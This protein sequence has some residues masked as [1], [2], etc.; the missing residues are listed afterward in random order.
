M[1]K[2]E[3]EEAVKGE[4]GMRETELKY[5]IRDR[6]DFLD[7]R[8][9]APWGEREEPE[10]QINDYFDTVALAL[11]SRRILLRIRSRGR[12]KADEPAVLTLKYGREVAE[13]LFDSMEVECTIDGLTRE[14]ARSA[15]ESLLAL[16]VP[17]IIEL[18]SLVGKPRLA[19]AGSLS[20]ERTRR[21]IQGLV[22]E[23]DRLQFPDGSEAYE[24]E[25]ET[26]EPEAARRKV[27]ALAVARGI[28]LDPLRV[29]KF[30]RLLA[31]SGKFLEEA[32][33]AAERRDA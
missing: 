28:R 14:A 9:A 5:A 2:A 6:G 11:A 3:R 32:P 33:P 13:G 16:D 31:H 20:T 26:C 19:L 29:T 23:V 25:V 15:P 12:G 10:S 21:R 4:D 24:L 30:E 22:L 1:A 7:L 17:P 18:R 27:E 8:D